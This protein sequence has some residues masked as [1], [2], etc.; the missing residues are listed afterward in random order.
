MCDPIKVIPKPM[1]IPGHIK[2]PVPPKPV[3]NPFYPPL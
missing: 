1:P 3:P 2:R